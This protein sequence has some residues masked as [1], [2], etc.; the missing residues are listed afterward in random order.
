M[1]S[2]AFS[3]PEGLGK[4][5]SEPMIVTSAVG[6]LGI[7]TDSYRQCAVDDVD[8]LTDD[9]AAE[10]PGRDDGVAPVPTVVTTEGT[11]LPPG[12][13]GGGVIDVDVLAEAHLA[14]LD[15]RPY[16]RQV[17]HSFGNRTSAATL[18]VESA[19]RYRYERA[20]RPGLTNAPEFGDGTYLYSRF[21]QFST[22]FTVGPVTDVRSRHGSSV[23]R[24]IRRYLNHSDATVA[25]TRVDGAIGYTVTAERD[26][27]D[28]SGTTTDFRARAIVAPDGLVR[29]LDVSYVDQH[30][31]QP[32][33]VSY[34]HRYERRPITVEW[35]AWV[36]R[37]FRVRNRTSGTDA[38]DAAAPRSVGRGQRSAEASSAAATSRHRSARTD[39]P[40]AIR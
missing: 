18:R 38:G 30:G 13:S 1:V 23:A 3:D 12:I 14:A 36:D 10:S 37:E 26:R 22:R 40:L 7:L 31:N 21:V 2:L 24:S 4:L 15:G 34:S 33:N 27:Y 9:H 35:P 17:D 29:A 39:T 32:L 25:A 6:V 11:T 19:T 8:S 20:D 5:G 28:A 16:V